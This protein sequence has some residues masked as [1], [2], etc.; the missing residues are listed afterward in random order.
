MKEKSFLQSKAYDYIKEQILEGKLVPDTLYSEARLSKEL[1]I[2]RTPIREALQCLSQDGYI[3][4]VPSK[5]FMLRHLSNKDMQETIEV[6]CAIEGFCTHIIAGQISTEKGK[7][8]LNELGRILD[9]MQMAK[10]LDD[11]LQTFIDSDHAF[12]LAI[13]GYAENDEFNQLFQRLLYL[14]HLTSAT[15]LSVTGRVDGTL[16]EHQLYYRALREGNGNDA[17]QI[18]IR[19]LT[20][21]LELHGHPDGQ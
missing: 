12:H 4:I 8:L 14:I 1:D 3:S 17:Y 11:N 21:P 6:R 20:M 13:V 15:A 9:Q 2:S 18:M 7:Q 16:E 10:D 19:H 5:G